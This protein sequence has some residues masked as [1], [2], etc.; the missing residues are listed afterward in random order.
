MGFFL[1]LELGDGTAG[2]TM[3]CEMY[4]GRTYLMV[5]GEAATEA[6]ST[7]SYISIDQ[8]CGGD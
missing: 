7:S 5:L 4:L 8:M 3:G 1:R 6:F 2:W